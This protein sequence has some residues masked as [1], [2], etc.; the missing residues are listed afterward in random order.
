MGYGWHDLYDEEVQAIRAGA[1]LFAQPDRLRAYLS[2]GS[3][4][5]VLDHYRLLLMN[6]S[7][8]WTTSLVKLHKCIK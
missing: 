8:I 1:K 4:N 6:F 2:F 7:K 5:F 3:H